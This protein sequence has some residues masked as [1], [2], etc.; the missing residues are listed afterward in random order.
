MSDLHPILKVEQAI[1]R[2]FACPC[3]CSSI[4]AALAALGVA[5]AAAQTPP[6]PLPTFDVASVKPNTGRG[7]QLAAD[8]AIGWGDVT[9]KVNLLH[10]QLNDV[11]LRAYGIEPYQ[12]SGPG[13]LDND[14]INIVAVVPAGAPK[15]KIPLMF[16]ALIEDR[17]QLKY[18]RETQVA[19]VYALVVAAGGPKLVETVPDDAYVPSTEKDDLSDGKVTITS[20]GSG[21]FGKYKLRNANDLIHTQFASMTMKMLAEFF[22]QYPDTPSV[23]GFVDLPI[24]DMTGLKGSYQVTPDILRSDG[25]RARRAAPPSQGDAG[26]TTPTA[27]EPGGNSVR[28]SLAKMGLKLERRRLPIEKLVID[29]IER[30]PTE[31]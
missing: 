17:F 18:H 22:N 20:E 5:V 23:I 6:S 12:L 15:Q 24:V 9:G 19:P 3:K 30:T 29:H 11:L 2:R 4:L 28:E 14:P 31:N 13:W 25:P 1:R 16:Q 8:R 7:G 21:P 26:Q 27:S 10:V